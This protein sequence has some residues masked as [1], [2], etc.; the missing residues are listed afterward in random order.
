MSDFKIVWAQ[1]G[2]NSLTKEGST[3]VEGQIA[4]MQWPHVRLNPDSNPAANGMEGFYT[5]ALADEFRQ[6][7]R[8][9]RPDENFGSTVSENVRVVQ[10]SETKVH[11][12][13]RQSRRHPDGEEYNAFETLWLF[14]KSVHEEDPGGKPRPSTSILHRRLGPAEPCCVCRVGRGVP[15]ELPEQPPGAGRRGP[16]ALVMQLPLGTPSFLFWHQQQHADAFAQPAKHADVNVRWCALGGLTTRLERFCGKT[17]RSCI[18]RVSASRPWRCCGAGLA[19][20]SAAANGCGRLQACQC[21][22]DASA[23]TSRSCC[24]WLAFSNCATAPIESWV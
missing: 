11:F 22:T 13:I 5:W 3:P 9:P 4:N 1:E 10:A 17:K 15:L 18:L 19:R 14:T 16:Q 6:S 12:A 7:W 8:P 20:S 24:C 23:A 21:P 2:W